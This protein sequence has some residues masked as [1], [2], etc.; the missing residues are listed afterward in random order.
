MLSLWGYWCRG[1]QEV[2]RFRSRLRLGFGSRGWG[3]P[4]RVSRDKHLTQALECGR[5]H[6]LVEVA[7][8]FGNQKGPLSR[9]GALQ[10]AM[11]LCCN[12]WTV[13]TGLTYLCSAPLACNPKLSLLT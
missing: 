3:W 5:S 12:G 13:E 7:E 4:D 6:L 10:L 11:C 1:K 2:A 8:V 9:E